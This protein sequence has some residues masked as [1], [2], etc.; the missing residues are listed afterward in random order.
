METQT[1]TTDE[2]QAWMNAIDLLHLA[3]SSDDERTVS[4]DAG[5]E[6]WTITN[7]KYSAA[8]HRLTVEF[9]DGDFYVIV[10]YAIQTQMLIVKAWRDCRMRSDS[11]EPETD[12]DDSDDD[13]VFVLRLFYLLSGDIRKQ[14]K[15]ILTFRDGESITFSARPAQVALFARLVGMLE[16]YAG[17]GTEKLF[18]FRSACKYAEE[19]QTLLTAFR[20]MKKGMFDA[21]KRLCRDWDTLNVC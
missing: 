20:L 5:D 17:L 13:S 18:D 12:N 9:D 16:E 15:K 14:S 3:I 4:I 1:K 7:Y 21:K 10:E 6:V 8:R 19:Q 2:E 11:T